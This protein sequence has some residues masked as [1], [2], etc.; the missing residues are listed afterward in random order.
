MRTVEIFTAGCPICDDLVHEVQQSACESCD[1]VVLDMRDRAVADRAKRLGVRSVPAVAIDGEL[2]GCC[3][4]G[5]PDLSVLRQ[6]G[7]GRPS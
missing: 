1:V 7:L 2:A 4:S 5:G 6:A 3:R